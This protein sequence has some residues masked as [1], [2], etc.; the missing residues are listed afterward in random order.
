MATPRVGI[1]PTADR[2]AIIDAARKLKLDPYEFGA[3]L[4]LEAGPDMDPNIVGGAGN[5]HRGLIQFGPNEQKLYGIT[6]NQT[7]AQ[8][9]PAVLQ[10]FQ[11]RGYKPGMGIERAYATVLGGNPNVS[12]NAED[13]FGTSVAKV[14]KRFKPGGDYYQNAVRVLGDVGPATSP[15]AT[16]PAKPKPEQQELAGQK[17]LLLRFAQELFSPIL[18]PGTTSGT[19]NTLSQFMNLLGTMGQ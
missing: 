13:S 7:R 3:F 5:R 17:P 2:Q 18:T 14:S 9:I 19:T 12:L 6:G 1:L 8:Q 15:V 10:Y 4:S 11:D 16:T